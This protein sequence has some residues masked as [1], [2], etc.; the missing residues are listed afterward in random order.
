MMPR[1]DFDTMVSREEEEAKACAQGG[2]IDAEPNEE[3][4]DEDLVED[5]EDAREIPIKERA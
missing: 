2:N 3:K 5:N 4:D 1:A